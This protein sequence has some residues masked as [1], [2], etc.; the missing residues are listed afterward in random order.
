MLYLGDGKLSDSDLPKRA[1]ITSMVMNAHAAEI[2]AIRKELQ[3]SEGR[4]SFTMDLWT[5]HNLRPFMS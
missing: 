4:I 1:A 2:I 3:T 5:D